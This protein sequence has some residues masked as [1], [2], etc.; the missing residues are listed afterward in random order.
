MKGYNFFGIWHN[1]GG[2]LYKAGGKIAAP[3]AKLAFLLAVALTILSFASCGREKSGNLE[4][5]YQ[6]ETDSYTLAYY[7]DSANVSTLEIPDTFKDKPVT[8]IGQLAIGSCDTLERIVIGKNIESIDKWGIVDCRYLKSIEVDEE[9][10]Y[11]SSLDGVLYSKD[12]TKIITYPNAHTADYAKDGKLLKAASYAVAPGVKVIGHCA[13]YKCY[14]LEKVA[15]PDSVE[16][17]EDRAFH[18]CEA[19][20]DI[21]FPEGLRSIGKDAFLGC[22]GLT[23]ITLPSSIRALGDYAFYNADNIKTLR[24]R[25]SQE[26]V[27]LGTKW[28]PTSAGRE[29]PVNILW[30]ER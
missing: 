4:F 21:N 30:E 18:K 16:E 12:M 2:G 27:D 8:A 15:L 9:N 20:T 24:I 25:T 17:I 1:A 23:E 11:F 28:Y 26:N 5:L 22:K 3:T 19:M 6:E 10:G 13:F 29:I 14:G 7:N